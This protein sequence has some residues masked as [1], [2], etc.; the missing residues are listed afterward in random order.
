MPLPVEGI[1][2]PRRESHSLSES[3]WGHEYRGQSAPWTIGRA[4]ANCGYCRILTLLS[5]C[6]VVVAF[7]GR[8]G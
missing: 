2:G 4:V 6:A 1:H 7:A 5:V 3:W 8:R